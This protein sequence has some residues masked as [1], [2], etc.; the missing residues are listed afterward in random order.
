MRRGD[1][2]HALETLNAY[3]QAH[4][5]GPFAAQALALRIVAL[6]SSGKADEATTLTREFQKKFPNRSLDDDGT[7]APEDGGAVGGKK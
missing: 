1:Y 6:K 5:H 4:P 7:P 2:A 3:D